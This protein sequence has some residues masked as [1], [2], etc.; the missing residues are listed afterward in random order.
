MAAAERLIQDL[1]RAAEIIDAADLPQDLRALAFAQILAVTLGPSIPADL[2]APRIQHPDERQAGDELLARIEARL[3]VEHTILQRVYEEYDGRL[4]L[5]IK[6][7]ML[8]S[9]KSKASAMREV[10]LVT[11]AGRQAAGLEDKTPF[12]ILRGECDE[13]D[14]LDG[15]NFATEIKRLSVKIE[16]SGR[17]KDVRVL[18]HGMDEAAKL[19]RKM[20]ERADT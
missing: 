17:K 18:R 19:I 15:P 9:P 10:S 2:P 20:A 11:A 6:R 16:G 7:T 5:T 3:G 14:V 12:E 4:L 13:L 8:T 1:K